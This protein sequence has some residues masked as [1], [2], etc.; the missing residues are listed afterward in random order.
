MSL[1]SLR[2]TWKEMSVRQNLKP[3]SVSAGTGRPHPRALSL[4]GGGG[5]LQEGVSGRWQSPDALAQQAL[6]L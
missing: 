3:G 5:A 6:G 4:G 2:R 1:F